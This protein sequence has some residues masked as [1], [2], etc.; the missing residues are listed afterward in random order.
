MGGFTKTVLLSLLVVQRLNS[1]A[2]PHK[3][4]KCIHDQVRLVLYVCVCGFFLKK[5]RV[6]ICDLKCMCYAVYFKNVG[7]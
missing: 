6:L 5:L 3:V 2:T 4:H 1:F 7:C